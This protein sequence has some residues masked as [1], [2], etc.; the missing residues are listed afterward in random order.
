M[1]R[2][3]KLGIAILAIVLF[4]CGGLLSHVA[5]QAL[6]TASLDPCATNTA[7]KQAGAAITTATTTALVVGSGTTNV[8]VCSIL[9]TNVSSATANTVTFEQGSGAT[10]G[11]GTATIGATL[12]FSTGQAVVPMAG[13]VSLLNTTTAGNGICVVT[14][15]GTTPFIDIIISYIQQ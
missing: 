5:G 11:T 8:Y 12:T 4:L 6:P 9:M 7:K 15:V 3:T 13:A 2:S 10:C 14:T 1:Q